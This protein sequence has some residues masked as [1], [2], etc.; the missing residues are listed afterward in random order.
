MALHLGERFARIDHRIA[1]LRLHPL[2][3]LKDAKEFLRL[4]ADQGGIAEAQV[5]GAQAG[6]RIAER[7]T[8]KS[9]RSQKLRQPGVIVNQPAGRHAGGG[10]QA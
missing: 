2:D 10:L 6:Q 5:A 1:R 7:A 3:P 4:I 9:Q 8:G